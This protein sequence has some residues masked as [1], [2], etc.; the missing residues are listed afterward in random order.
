MWAIMYA[1]LPALHCGYCERMFMPDISK[2]LYIWK[3]NDPD[4]STMWCYAGGRRYLIV[5]AIW[6]V[7]RNGIYGA[8]YDIDLEHLQAYLDR[9][10]ERDASYIETLEDDH[11]IAEELAQ[12][13]ECEYCDRTTELF[14]TE[15]EL[16]A[17]VKTIRG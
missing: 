14:D 3:K 9:L 7:K 12:C 8:I 13:I 1:I 11:E 15:E 4:E 10:D 5:N 2:D 16:W 6:D 17:Y